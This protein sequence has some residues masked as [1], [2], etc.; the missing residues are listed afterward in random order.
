MAAEPTRRAVL[1]MAAVSLPLAG[2]RGIGALGPLPRTGPDVRALDQAIAAEQLMI[3]R[4]EAAVAA[5]A[6]PDSSASA[7]VGGILAEHQQHLARLRGRLIL[8]PRLA[9]ASPAA[10]PSPPRLPAGRARLLA[11]LAEAERA[12]AATLAA[13]L[14]RVPAALA[15]LMASISA[16]EATHA[17][18]LGKIHQSAGLRH[19]TG[20]GA[21]GQ[22]TPGQQTPGQRTPGQRATG[23][24][25][26]RAAVDALQTALAAEQAASYGYGIVG[27]HL[28]GTRLLLA[29]T[30][31][32]AHQRARDELT[33][34]I[35]ARGEQ[36][37]PAA[38]AYQLPGPVRTAAEAVALAVMIERQATAAYLPLIAQADP[39]LREF[40]ARRMQATAVG[41]ARW[42]GRPQPFPGLP[43]RTT[44]R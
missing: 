29:T 22:R 44:T 17:V 35:A 9:T 5:L 26:G 15:Q 34:M 7:L 3:A 40:A 19:G 16:S 11:D 13:G 43:R 32:V 10:A 21:P 23:T 27:A 41:A 38:V 12:A 4:Y 28:T 20:H 8:P 25:G 39:L 42:T 18:L 6:G 31:W 24:A 14:A 37:H 2:C 30:D 36:P 33:A 1:A